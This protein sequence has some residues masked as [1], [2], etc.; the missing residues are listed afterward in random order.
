MKP[1][2]LQWLSLGAGTNLGDAAMKNYEPFTYLSDV[3]RKRGLDVAARGHVA[4]TTRL[5]F[6]KLGFHACRILEAER[7][8]WR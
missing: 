6:P 3:A 2:R 4:S 1:R 5:H 8:A 7:R